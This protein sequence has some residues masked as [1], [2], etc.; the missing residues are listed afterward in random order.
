[1]GTEGAQITQAEERI[2]VPLSGIRDGSRQGQMVGVD[3]PEY[4]DA[5]EFTLGRI[6][7]THEKSCPYP[8]RFA[9][10]APLT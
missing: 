6:L 2:Y 10:M 3:P 9:Q 8:G 1:M 4:G 5:L 7:R